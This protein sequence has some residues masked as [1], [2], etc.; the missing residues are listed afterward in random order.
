MNTIVKEEVA[1]VSETNPSWKDVGERLKEL[2]E[3]YGKEGLDIRLGEEDAG[4]AFA[5]DGEDGQF[6]NISSPK[7]DV[8]IEMNTN[9]LHVL[10]LTLSGFLGVSEEPQDDQILAAWRDDFAS[11]M[12]D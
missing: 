10:G 12:M 1:P 4:F 5:V 8:S 9:Q 2:G 3:D 11:R 6:L 7:G